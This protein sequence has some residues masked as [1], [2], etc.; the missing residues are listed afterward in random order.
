LPVNLLANPGFEASAPAARWTCAAG[1]ATA[2]G[3]HSGLYSLSGTPTLTSTAECAQ[4]VPVRASSS[5]TLSGWVRGGY[6]F[7]GTELGGTWA[8]PSGQ[9][10]RLS[11]TFTTGPSTT[12]VRVHAHGWYAQAAFSVDDLALAGPDS[13]TTVPVPPTDLAPTETT[14]QSVRLTWTGSPG[15]SRYRIYQDGAL[16][17]TTASAEP[18]AALSGLAPGS[19]HTFAV[20][21]VSSAGESAPSAPVTANLM[22]A[23]AAPPYAPRSV[24]ATSPAPG[25]VWL[26]WEAV[27]TA[28]DGYT[29]YCDG[30]RT[31]WS[32]GPAS[33]AYLAPG[34]HVCEVTALN[35]AG[36]SPRSAPV[37]VTA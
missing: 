12:S 23:Q 22:P 21:A 25:Q 18:A 32:Y 24:V 16:L 36:E 33:L 37:T 14:S 20:S 31:T 11:V 19:S 35:S 4:V 30:A 1:T 6:A 29:V 7:L 2:W 9:W 10:T 28:S 26:A 27:Q 34:P 13:L 15:A 5:Y 3:G 8:P 17:A